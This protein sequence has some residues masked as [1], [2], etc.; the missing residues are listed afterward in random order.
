[1]K[2]FK[3]NMTGSNFL[4]VSVS[5]C[6]PFSFITKNSNKCASPFS[7]ILE[8][9]LPSHSDSVDLIVLAFRHWGALKSP[10][11]LKDGIKEYK[12]Y[13]K[14]VIVLGFAISRV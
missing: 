10:Q 6:V 8:E 11:S 14:E 2:G 7:F 4:Q 9:Y 5:G 13:A 12:K 3:K 1:M